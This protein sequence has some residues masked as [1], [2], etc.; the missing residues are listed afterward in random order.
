ML[1]RGGWGG[2]PYNGLYGEAPP[3]RG[4]FSWMAVYKR[5]GISW[6]KV[7]K[8]V[9]KTYISVLKGSFKYLDQRYLTAYSCKYLRDCSSEKFSKSRFGGIWKGS[10]FL[11]KVCERGT[12]SIKNGIH[13]IQ[14][15]LLWALAIGYWEAIVWQSLKFLYAQTIAFQ[16]PKQPFLNWV[17]TI[18]DRKG[19]P[20]T[21]LP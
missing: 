6:V 5:V 14:K 8:R 2:T 4:T 7:Y 19:T 11:W 1:R 21:Y 9:G 20:F 17:Y 10:H 16:C 3:E 13:L 18:F 12:F 15:R